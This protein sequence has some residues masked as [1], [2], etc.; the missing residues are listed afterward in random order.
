MPDPKTSHAVKVFGSA[1]LALRRTALDRRHRQI[2]GIKVAART[3]RQGRQDK[4]SWRPWRLDGSFLFGIFSPHFRRYLLDPP[5][6]TDYDAW[7]AREPACRPPA[8]ARRPTRRPPRPS[9]SGEQPPMPN[10]LSFAGTP[11]PF[12]AFLALC[13]GL[14][15]ALPAR[16]QQPLL[17]STY[18]A[19]R[20]VS[21]LPA[22]GKA[23]TVVEAT[24]AG[25]D[26][27]EPEKLLFSSPGFKAE[28]VPPP[29]PDPKARRRRSRP[30]SPTSPRPPSSKS[31][32]PPTR[33]WGS[34][35]SVSSANGASA[36]PAPSWSATCPRSWKRSRTT[37]CRRPS[38]SR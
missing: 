30:G 36:T 34:P 29:P 13:A 14:L 31:P 24:V 38:A 15:A 12:A 5:R 27:D 6:R 32:S 19:P 25:V 37:M 11:R 20:F 4:A 33:R 9:I 21:I 10:R 28:L 22:G 23:G 18:P 35:I 16:A 3:N 26:F 1:I 2:K 17:D 8:A 7:L